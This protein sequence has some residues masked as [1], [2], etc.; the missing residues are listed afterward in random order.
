MIRYSQGRLLFI[1]LLAAAFLA[2]I[3]GPFL[4][5]PA[6]AASEPTGF[7]D[8][9]LTIYPEYDDPLRL[10]YPTIL[11][12]LDGQIEGVEPPATVRFLVP[13][14]A[15]MYSAGSGPRES[16]VGGPPNRKVSDIEGWDE[17]SYD[18]RTSYFV[19]EYY[20]PIQTS[21][22]KAFSASLIPLYPIDGLTAIAQEPRQ[23]TNFSVAP[24]SQAI[25]Q[26]QYVDA[27]G[28]NIHEY[29]YGTM[30]SRQQVSFSIA[31]TK[32]N[33]AP[34]LDITAGASSAGLIIGAGI[35]A[36]L[37]IGTLVY[38]AR[39]RS[40]SRR[41]DKRQASGKPQTKKSGRARFCAKCG[42]RRE[43]S[44]RFCPQCGTKWRA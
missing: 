14:D 34:S 25:R 28:F 4:G 29:S 42:A 19:V 22:D 36:A 21:P 43:D 7:K 44:G 32:E 24:Q 41:P 9:V 3:G 23:A 15:V 39:K 38:L 11:V 20:A 30:D 18:L 35:A 5:M 33:P 31:Y 6:S 16:Y 26:R 8:V 12:M 2:A 17:I 37:L 1:L 27:Q 10:G 40:S 13:R